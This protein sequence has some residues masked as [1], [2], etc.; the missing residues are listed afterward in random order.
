MRRVLGVVLTGLGAFLLVLALL[1]RF[2]LPGQ[3]IKFPLN[4]YTVSDLTGTNVTYFSDG[5]LTE[6]TGATVRAASTVQGDVAAGSSSTAVWVDTTGVFDITS[7]PSPGTPIAYSNERIAFNRRTGLV[8]NCCGAAI[9]NKPVKMS[10]QEFVWP[11]GTQKK[12]YQIFDTT[13]LKPETVKFTGT[14][15]VDGMNVDVFVESVANQQFKTVSLPGSLVG[16]KDQST[17]TLPEDLTATNT[18]YVD[19]GSGSPLK[20]VENQT[21][22]LRNPTT[23]AT[24]LT[25]L[26]G[27]L[28]TTPKSIAA[29]V[30]T[31]KS[32]DNEITWVQNIGPLIGGLLGLLLLVLGILLIVG[33]Y[34]DDYYEYEDE[35][36]EVPAGA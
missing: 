23:G 20:V 26:H 22:F 30:S 34:D 28:T 36:A 16:I 24:A 4:E 15:T 19:P 1:F 17:V 7:G 31:A 21:E 14:S 18:Y 6:V 10:G 3:V 27:T 29:A 13:L 8:V 25:L 2:Y 5:S 9:D 32:S 12:N 11:I 35:D 33:Q